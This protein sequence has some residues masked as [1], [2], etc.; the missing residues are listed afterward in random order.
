MILA[1]FVYI[2]IYKAYGQVVSQQLHDQSAVL[3]A[4]LVQ[5]VE[6]GDGVV[7]SLLGQVASSFRRV[8]D[9]VVEHGEV[10][11]ETQTNRVSR[12]HLRFGNVESF[13][14]SFLRVLDD[15]FIIIEGKNF[16]SKL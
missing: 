3:V 4:V 16:K 2:Y 13:G 12:W 9:F 14:V 11:S 6:L 1:K 10:Q 15:S 5:G 7:E 8:E